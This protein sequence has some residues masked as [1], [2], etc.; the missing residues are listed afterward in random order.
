MLEVFCKEV[1]RGRVLAVMISKF[2]LDK[3]ENDPVMFDRF[4]RLTNTLQD[5]ERLA[6]SASSKLRINPQ[7]R[8]R[9]ARN[10]RASANR[11][12]GRRNAG[13]YED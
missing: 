10:V 11:E 4:C 6:I 9:Q 3:I 5:C 7:N 12:A 8:I 13:L 2:S 1:V